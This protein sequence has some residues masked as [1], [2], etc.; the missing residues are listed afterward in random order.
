MSQPDTTQRLWSLIRQLQG[1]AVA[2]EGVRGQ[3]TA[4]GT[5][6]SFA[7]VTVTDNLGTATKRGGGWEHVGGTF[8]G[9]A[10][11]VRILSTTANTTTL[12]VITRL[13]GNI[14]AGQTVL[15]DY[16]IWAG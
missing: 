13:G 6:V 9:D 1:K 16:W 12:R 8:T 11:F 10:T 4:T 2:L 15:L 3:A 7:D 14:T 5:G